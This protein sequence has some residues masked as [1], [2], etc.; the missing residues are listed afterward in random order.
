MGS[1]DEVLEID[2]SRLAVGLTLQSRNGPQLRDL[3]A[4]LLK[5]VSRRTWG[6]NDL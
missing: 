3:P 6:D 1:S 2:S 4:A 5:F